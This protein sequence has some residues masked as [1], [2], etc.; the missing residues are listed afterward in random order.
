VLEVLCKFAGTAPTYRLWVDNEVVTELAA[1]AAVGGA[2]EPA[3]NA[4][5]HITI[6]FGT[7]KTRR[8]KL[9]LGGM[10]PSALITTA[11][12]SVIAPETPSI[13]VLWISDSFLV[14]TS[15]RDGIAPLASRQLG[16]DCVMVDQIGGTGYVAING[17]YSTIKQRLNTHIASKPDVIVICSGLNDTFNSTYYADVQS[18]LAGLRKGLPEVPMF[19]VGPWS[20][21][22][23]TNTNKAT[24]AQ[25]IRDATAT[26]SNA[27]FIDTMLG[28]GP[29]M[30]PWVIGT[31]KVGSPANNGNADFVVDTDGTHPSRTSTGGFGETYYAT[32]IA[33]AIASL[34]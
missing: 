5:G 9:E 20:N 30:N 2:G 11:S 34:I 24:V 18:T 17:V 13:R 25:A 7:R 6:N 32:R 10:Y 16:W 21:G 19:V 28:T 14:Q 12:D 15:S 26:I 8:V 3:Q 33:T 29:A 27:Y 4:M 23:S 31:G 1:T 22:N